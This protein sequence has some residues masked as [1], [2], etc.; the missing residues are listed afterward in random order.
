MYKTTLLQEEPP[1]G[2]YQS[3]ADTCVRYRTADNSEM[4]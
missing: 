1:S 3:K 2:K 4:P